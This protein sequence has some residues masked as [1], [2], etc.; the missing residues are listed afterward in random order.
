MFNLQ[1]K[2]VYL[3]FSMCTF[4]VLML[5]VCLS[6]L[7]HPSGSTWQYSKQRSDPMCS[8]GAKGDAAYV[9]QVAL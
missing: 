6:A 1:D 7:P 2:D 4:D 3:L 5:R 8:A 9:P